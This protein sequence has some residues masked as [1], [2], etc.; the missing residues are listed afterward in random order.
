MSDA[1]MVRSLNEDAFQWRGLGDNARL[2]AVADGMGGHFSGEVA[3]QLATRTA[4]RSIQRKFGDKPTCSFSEATK[5][6]EEGFE[7]A[8][9][10]VCTYAHEHRRHMGTTLVCALHVVENGES[11]VFIGHSGDSR[12]YRWRD[13]E[14]TRLTDDHSMVA[15][16]VAAGKIT[17]AE[18]RTHPKSNVLLSFLGNAEDLE[19]EIE[20]FDMLP[21][22]R[23]LICS[24]GLWGEVLDEKIEQLLGSDIDP[25]RTVNR[26]LRAANDA[27]GSDN[28]TAVILDIPWD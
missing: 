22:D 9:L 28:V 17:E 12:A 19:P 4:C 15:A 8:N 21:G 13:G 5:L 1:G 23:V 11:K 27:G 10:A 6:L 26:L 2:V 7:Q 3:A 16:M 24:D 25:R 18:A 20:S 14:L